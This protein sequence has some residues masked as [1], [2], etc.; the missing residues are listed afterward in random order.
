MIRCAV[1]GGIEQSVATDRTLDC[2]LSFRASLT[3]SM[4]SSE[5]LGGRPDRSQSSTV[6]V[7]QNR[8]NVSL[9]HVKPGVFI[10]N[11]ALNFR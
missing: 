8:S 10:P 5:M 11:S 6:P 7:S 9:I 4:V 2:D 3:M 1:V